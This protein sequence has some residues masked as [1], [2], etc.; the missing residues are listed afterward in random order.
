MWGADSPL[1]PAKEP[2]TYWPCLGFAARCRAAIKADP[3]YAQSMVDAF[4]SDEVL[5]LE[6][7]HVMC[8]AQLCES[9]LSLQYYQMSTINLSGKLSPLCDG[10]ARTVALR[11]LCGCSQC[12]RL[13]SIDTLAWDMVGACNCCCC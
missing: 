1:T 8:A 5:D 2:K 11:Y 9:S 4:E 7:R 6:K 3:S 12:M 10:V 13:Q